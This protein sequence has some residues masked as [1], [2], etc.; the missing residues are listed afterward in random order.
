MRRL[1]LAGAL[2]A[3]VVLAAAMAVANAASINPSH[4]PANSP[5]LL[6]TPIEGFRYDWGRGCK[7][8]DQ[9]PPGMH[10]LQ[11]WLTRKVPRGESWGIHNCHVLPGG[12]WSLH[13]DN[14][15]I[16]WHLDVTNRAD[17]HE[18]MELIHTLLA[19]DDR[20]NY[21][22]LARRM[23]IQGF[24]YNCHFW[25]ARNPTAGMQRYS[26]CYN[27]HGHLRRHLDPTLAHMDHVHIELNL[28]GAREET[29]FWRTPV[30]RR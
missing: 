26:Y 13:S 17:R 4:N 20:G 11:R 15:A 19:K 27:S 25:W 16:D 29:S 6:H 14:R 30:S 9:I 12:H 22:A 28:P 18:A 8:P 1:A 5:R 24:I 10:A 7:A 2:G 21:A 23:G 3:L